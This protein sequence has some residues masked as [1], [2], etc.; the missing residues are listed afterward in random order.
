MWGKGL[1]P[2][3]TRSIIVQYPARNRT[4]LSPH[5]DAANITGSAAVVHI[6]E[7]MNDHPSRSGVRR[8][9]F[10]QPLEQCSRPQFGLNLRSRDHRAMQTARFEPAIARKCSSNGGIRAN[11]HLT[12]GVDTMG[13]VIRIVAVRDKAMRCVGFVRWDTT[14]MPRS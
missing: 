9:K 8:A 6:D 3:C 5:F 7:S 1:G 10:S 12:I 4:S 14:A 2:L 11:G 13:H